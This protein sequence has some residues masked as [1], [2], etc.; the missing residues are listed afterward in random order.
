VVAILA[1][2]L[3]YYQSQKQEVTDQVT[4]DLTSIG[5]LKVM[6]IESWRY[7]RLSDVRIIS[8]NQIFR[9]ALR[10]YLQ[11]P[12]PEKKQ[13]ILTMFSVWINATSNSRNIRYIDPEYH[14][15][16]GLTNDTT[17]SPYLRE[18][19]AGS[20]TAGMPFL[21]SFTRSPDDNAPEQD[22]CPGGDGDS[23]KDGGIYRQG[24][25]GGRCHLGNPAGTGFALVYGRG[26]GQR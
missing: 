4:G 25:P 23:R 7:E 6:E 26:N 16:L 12:D 5:S 14:V 21:T 3:V 2:G 11:N 8:Q 19:L 20:A 17:I 15:V 1:G 22:R 24:L 13:Q 10:G 18:Q 9:G